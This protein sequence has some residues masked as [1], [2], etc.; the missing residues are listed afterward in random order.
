[1]SYEVVNKRS[2][3][4]DIE[5]IVDHYKMIS[6]ALANTFLDRLEETKE[7]VVNYPLAFQIKYKNVRTILIKQFPYHIHYIVDEKR[8]QLIILAVIHA[9]KNQMNNDS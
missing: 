1:M 5:A 9:Y 8:Q 4:C 2:V 3:F 7:Y 6:A